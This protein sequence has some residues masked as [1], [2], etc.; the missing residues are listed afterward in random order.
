VFR[1]I[2]RRIKDNEGEEELMSYM[3]I[4]KKEPSKETGAEA[5]VGNP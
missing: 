4:V 5:A 1:D 2:Q 3:D